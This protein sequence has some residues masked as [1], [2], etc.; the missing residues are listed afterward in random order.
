MSQSLGLTLGPLTGAFIYDWVGYSG[1]FY[2][3][4]VIIFISAL[5][6]LCYVPNHL[7]NSAVAP[8][9]ELDDDYT[10]PITY[11]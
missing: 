3:F 4:A 2:F 11:C 1:T 10:S 8:A 9:V 6:C 5:F 7:N